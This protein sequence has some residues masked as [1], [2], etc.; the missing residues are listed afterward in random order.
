MNV[1][2][3]YLKFK[4][5]I[6]GEMSRC[7]EVDVKLAVDYKEKKDQ[8]EKALAALQVLSEKRLTKTGVFIDPNSEYWSLNPD[9]RAMAFLVPAVSGLP[10]FGALAQL[11]DSTNHYGLDGLKKLRGN[12]PQTL[13]AALEVVCASGFLQLAEIDVNM[14]LVIHECD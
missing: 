10:I 9:P 8:R 14:T 4:A 7:E 11:P 3:D 5:C 13:E 6:Q 2:V 12:S 1:G